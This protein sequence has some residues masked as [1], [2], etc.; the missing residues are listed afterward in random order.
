LEE[1]GVPRSH[2]GLC[3]DARIQRE[4][5]G[6][7]GRVAPRKERR[8]PRICPD[9]DAAQAANA[10]T[11]AVRTIAD[12]AAR[13]LSLRVTRCSSREVAMHAERPR[14]RSQNGRAIRISEGAIRAFLIATRSRRTL[15]QALCANFFVHV[16]KCL[17]RV[18]ARI[19]RSKKFFYR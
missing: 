2:V 11:D 9:C 5:I 7:G 16:Q 17:A 14:R 3:A 6:G 13:H 15:S 10:M 8:T 12:A 19:V 4:I 1:R 18:S